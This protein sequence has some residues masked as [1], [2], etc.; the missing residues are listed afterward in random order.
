MSNRGNADV[1]IV[2]AGPA[3][4]FAVFQLGIYGLRCHLVER[5]DRAGGQCTVLY[6]DKSIYDVPAFPEIGG[7][8]LT[9]RLLRQGA[10]CGPCFTFGR[11]A[12]ELALVDGRW[13]LDLDDG[14]AILAG[15]VILATGIGMFDMPPG[16]R[17][18][19]E[20]VPGPVAQWSLDRSRGGIHVDPATLETSRPGVFAI[21]DACDYPGKL[22][23][24]LSAFHEAALATQEI[25]KRH[26]GTRL[27]A[28]EYSTTSR[29][30]RARL[31]RS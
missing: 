12:V 22:K 14:T 7:D 3:A 4:L 26:A 6:P 1:L 28:V 31:G 20:L 16:E 11:S 23:L 9:E 13:Q 15:Y 5:L 24:I 21:G 18:G 25:R 19:V 2:G 8:D 10:P 29:R 27:P 30:V 17:G